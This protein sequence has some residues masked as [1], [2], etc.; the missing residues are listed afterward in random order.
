M[1][2]FQRENSPEHE[3]VLSFLRGGFRNALEHLYLKQNGFKY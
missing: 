1:F 3:V 2:G